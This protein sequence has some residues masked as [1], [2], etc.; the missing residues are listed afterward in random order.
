MRGHNGNPN[1]LKVWEE[2]VLPS[3]QKKERAYM[4]VILSRPNGATTKEVAA[5]L[6]VPI[7]TISGRPRKLMREGFLI[8]TGERRDNYGVHVA[9]PNPEQMSL[10]ECA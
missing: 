9:N 3:L 8:A 10:L 4:G 6:K 2:K 1:S 5:V 7:H